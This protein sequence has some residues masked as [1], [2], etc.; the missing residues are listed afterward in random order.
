MKTSLKVS[1]GGA[2]AALGL[3]LMLLTSLLQPFGTYAFPAFAGMLLVII[4]IEIGYAFALSVFAATS[5]LS[6][7]LVADKEAALMYVIFLG[8]YPIV[9]ALIE[10]IP[11]RPVQ[12]AVKLALFNAAMIGSFFIAVYVLSIPT[13]S[14]NIFGVYLP[15]VFL[16][17]GNVFFILYDICI[18]R[19]VTLYLQKWHN[20][21]NKN[22][23]L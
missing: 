6:F 19:L 11:S 17:A 12:Y 5:L 21:L 1:L 14:F 7:L 23:K 3:V 9:K 8:Y 18:T 20:K 16:I 15:W 2:V 10:R 4:V 22:T 13:E